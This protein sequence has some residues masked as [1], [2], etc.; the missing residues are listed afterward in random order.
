MRANLSGTQQAA[1]EYGVGAMAGGVTRF[2]FGREVVSA[3]RTAFAEAPAEFPAHLALSEQAAHAT[4]D[5]EAEP[6]AALA[7]LE[8]AAKSTGSW[9][10]S[11]R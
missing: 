8:E 6:N 2:I 9:I 3:A 5:A 4:N 7:A 11:W 1:I 10:A